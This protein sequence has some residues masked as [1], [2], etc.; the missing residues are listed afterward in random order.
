[1]SLVNKNAEITRWTVRYDYDTCWSYMQWCAEGIKWGK[2]KNK[3]F[4]HSSTPKAQVRPTPP[5]WFLV[6]WP[7][8]HTWFS[9]RSVFAPLSAPLTAQWREGN[10]PRQINTCSNYQGKETWI[11]SLFIC[12]YC[13]CLSWH[14]HSEEG[15]EAGLC[16]MLWKRLGC[17]ISEIRLWMS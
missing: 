8:G 17:K 16:D 12:T 2:I 7:P 15:T 1:M 4:I 11:D 5:P 3:D 14:V 6:T 13:T 9:W 10:L